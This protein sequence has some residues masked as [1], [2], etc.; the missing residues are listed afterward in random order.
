MPMGILSIKTGSWR[1]SSSLLIISTLY[2]VNDIVKNITGRERERE[3]TK[4][5]K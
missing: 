2:I 1:L 5:L 4:Y 3:R